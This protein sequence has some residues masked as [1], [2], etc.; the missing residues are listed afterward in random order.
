MG[1]GSRYRTQPTK[2]FCDNYDR[3]FGAKPL[4]NMESLQENQRKTQPSSKESTSQLA[5]DCSKSQAHQL[6]DRR[7]DT[8]D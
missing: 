3:I 4:N 2:R 8:E 6:K 7:L 1:K 5:S